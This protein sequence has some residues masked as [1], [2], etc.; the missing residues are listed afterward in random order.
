MLSLLALA[1]N[2]CTT[3]GRVTSGCEWVK[4]I[5]ISKSDVLTDGTADQILTHNLAWQRICD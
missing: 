1:L 4:P 2:A 5:Y 3:N